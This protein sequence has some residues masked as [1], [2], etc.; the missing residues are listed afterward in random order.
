[1]HNYD[2]KRLRIVNVTSGEEQRLFPEQIHIEIDGEGLVSISTPEIGSREFLLDSEQ[3]ELAK[4]E[5]G[6]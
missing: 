1:M 4:A 6:L 2:L 5:V 3:L